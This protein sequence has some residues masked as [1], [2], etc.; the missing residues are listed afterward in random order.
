MR[1]KLIKIYVT[2]RNGSFFIRATK[3]LRA[4]PIR[5]VALHVI[6]PQAK[7]NIAM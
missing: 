3:E 2:K 1:S 6:T 4:Y 7:C 5:P